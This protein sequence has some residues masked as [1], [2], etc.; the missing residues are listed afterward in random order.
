LRPV[1]FNKGNTGIHSTSG[2]QDSKRETHLPSMHSIRF[3]SRYVPLI[4]VLSAPLL[5]AATT[6]T[7]TTETAKLSRSDIAAIAKQATALIEVEKNYFGT[8]F[9]VHE[10]GLFIT[11][12]HV[13]RRL[14][15]DEG[16]LLILNSG[17]SNETKVR[18]KVIRT[19]EKSDLALLKTVSSISTFRPLP[20]GRDDQLAEL[21][22]LLVFGYPFGTAMS[23]KE[24]TYPTISANVV[25][26][27][28]LRRG[29]NELDFIQMDSALNPGNSGGPVIDAG[30]TVVGVVMGGIPG[31]GINLAIPSH[32]IT[33]LIEKPIVI[34]TPPVLAG[35]KPGSPTDLSIKVLPGSGYKGPFRVSVTLK[36]GE[37]SVRRYEMAPR[38][39]DYFVTV[40][41]L[42]KGEESMVDVKLRTPEVEISAP[43]V[44]ADFRIADTNL[45]LSEIK[46]YKGGTNGGTQLKSG[47]NLP[48]GP[49][50]QTAIFFKIA[51]QNVKIPLETVQSFEV[52]AQ[53]EGTDTSCEFVVTSAAGTELDRYTD[54]ISRDGSVRSLMDN[55]AQGGFARP[56]V[57]SAPQNW[58]KLR[59]ENLE[60]ERNRKE[61]VIPV[62]V[63]TEVNTTTSG[64]RRQQVI[65]QNQQPFFNGQNLTLR[66]G[67]WNLNFNARPSD[68]EL[69]VGTYNDAYRHQK[70][71]SPSLSISGPNRHMV[72]EIDGAFRVWELEYDKRTRRIT[73]LAI[74]FTLKDCDD[75]FPKTPDMYR[76]K[77]VS[78]MIRIN[79]SYR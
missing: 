48:G 54:V 40:P 10:T 61:E 46:N 52:G 69:T 14:S 31:A 56:A 66:V 35:K 16:A 3:A 19:D 64:A 2:E 63:F 36:C 78:G 44:D 17:T 41:Y 6:G 21:S 67:E 20:I 65:M 74:D 42:H 57:A 32:K 29:G 1:I 38:Q 47:K 77:S 13:V 51:G 27:S 23:L 53:S 58:L 59:I 37:E 7:P 39:N 75:N 49:S 60:G 68:K 30:G 28:S 43:A 76:L 34:F 5:R 24:A 55:L 9:C 70:E 12:A 33:K 26:I 11:N 72:H 8:A 4:F 22:E 79:S 45:K 73:K 71:G 62:P 15:S 50:G 25:N 18:A